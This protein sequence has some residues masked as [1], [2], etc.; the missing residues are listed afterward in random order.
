MADFVTLM[1]ELS[2][3]DGQAEINYSLMWVPKHRVG[4]VGGIK[5][6]L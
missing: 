4:G 6:V 2:R 1:I 3:D 5:I